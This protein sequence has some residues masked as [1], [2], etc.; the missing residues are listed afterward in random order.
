MLTQFESSITF[1]SHLER[2]NIYRGDKDAD[3]QDVSV[4]E[5]SLTHFFSS[6]RKF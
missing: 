4:R 6:A 2:A 1:S 5:T 3:L